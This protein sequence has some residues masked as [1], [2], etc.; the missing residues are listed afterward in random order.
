[1]IRE[2]PRIVFRALHED[3][4][5][6]AEVRRLILTDEVLAMPG[7]LAEVIERQDRTEGQ[8]AEVIKT[9]NEMLVVQNDMLATQSEM[10]ATQNEMLAS[11]RSML[12]SQRSMEATQ[13]LHTDQIGE[14]RGAELERRIARVLPSRLN[15]MYSLYRPQIVQRVGD[16]TPH[17]ERFLNDVEDAQ[18]AS[19]ISAS[20]RRRIEETDMIVRARRLNGAGGIYISVE[21]SATIRRGDIT[22]ANDTAVALR[23]VFGV[24]SAAVVAGYDIRPEDRRRAEDAGVT[25]IVLDNE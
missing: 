19:T 20:Q 6:L 24:E 4:E 2:N 22:R 17:T 8:L 3:A 11:Q 16:Q 23:A 14:L 1:M 15:P 9:Q 5:L 13:K 25:V 10:L 21:A 18:V 7:Q 12:A